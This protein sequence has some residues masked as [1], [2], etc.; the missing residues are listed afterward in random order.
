[1]T[2]NDFLKNIGLKIKFARMKKG[3]TQIQLAQLLELQDENNISNIECG[4]TNLTLK[5]LYKI[6]KV[7]EIDSLDLFKQ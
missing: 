6:G 1:M 2:E 7:L 5:S 3:L 4:R